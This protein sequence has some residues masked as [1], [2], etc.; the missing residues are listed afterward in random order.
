MSHKIVLFTLNGCEH[1]SSLKNRLKNLSIPYEEIDVELN[2]QIWGQVVDQTGEDSVP[3][4]FIIGE[5]DDL[6]TIFVP[7]V[8]YET[9][10]EIVEI[11][12]SHV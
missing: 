12:K 2:E 8:D 4:T 11:I 6:G 7:G 9:E 1:C 3:T 10:D 5:D